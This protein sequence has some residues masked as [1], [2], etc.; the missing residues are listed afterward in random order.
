MGKFLGG[1]L[2]TVCIFV[3]V[4]ILAGLVIVNRSTGSSSDSSAPASNQQTLM[5]QEPSFSVTRG[6]TTYYGAISSDVGVAILG[7]RDA[8]PV[9]VGAFGN[10]TRADGKF[11]AVAVGITNKQNTAIRMDSGLFELLDSTGNVYSASEK[12]IEAG[13]D[14]LFLSQINPGV[15]KAG[16]VLFDVPRDLSL[17]GLQLRFRG[18]MTG[19]SALLPLKV[20]SS[21][22]QAVVPSDPSPPAGPAP[23]NPTGQPAPAGAP[24]SIAIGQ[25]PEQVVAVLG[26]P[27]SIT[28]GAQ[29]V[30]TYP[31]L[32]VMFVDGKVSEVH[33]D[34]STQ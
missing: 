17:D 20:K 21:E 28:T 18:G 22:Q 3:A 23:P 34:Q 5:P 33:S 15:S 24:A 2:A 27:A 4:F 10:V 8:G 19:D 31:H 29:H 1:C 25:T 32:T 14:D 12:S 9:L 11:I 30:Y 26:Q 13:D 16:V 7:V 6:N